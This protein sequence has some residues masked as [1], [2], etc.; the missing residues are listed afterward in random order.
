MNTITVRP[1]ATLKLLTLAVLAL[2][3]LLLS[4][5]HW[6]GEKGNGNITTQTREISEF[7][8]LEV[9]GAF[10]ITWAPGPPALKITTDENL[11]EFIRTPVSGN[12]LRL[13]WIKPLKGT[14]GIKVEVTSPALSR[15]ELNGAVKLEAG[16]LSG[17]EFYLE[18][19]GAT[20]VTLR[21]NVNALSGELNGA[22]KLMAEALQTRAMELEINGAGK[23]DVSV[24]EALKVQVSGAG[25]VTYSGNPTVAQEINGAGSVKK[26]E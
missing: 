6:V 1:F 17:P 7:S 10:T 13:D 14:R 16:D 26:R 15:T 2:L 21:G 9:D 20:R 3:L 22:S 11:H 8:T 23:A 4:G 24:S 25:K 19:N 5:C 12:R 18:A